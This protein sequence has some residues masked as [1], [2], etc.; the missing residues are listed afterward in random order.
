MKYISDILEIQNNPICFKNRR[1]TTFLQDHKNML[2][3]AESIL[4]IWLG[5]HMHWQEG[6]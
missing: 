1:K 3:A 2:L 6:A 4:C 5:P